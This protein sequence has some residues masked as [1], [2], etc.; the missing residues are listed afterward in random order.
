[1]AKTDELGYFTSSS[2]RE[3]L[4]KIMSK[5]Y[6]IPAFAQHLK[7][8]ESEKRG[9]VLQRIGWPRRYKFRFIDPLME[10]YV[11]MRGLSQNLIDHTMLDADDK[12]KVSPVEPDPNETLPLL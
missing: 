3:P 7:D 11:V 10:P 8:F 1:L 12:A 9:P 2:I 5:K 6:E 4:F